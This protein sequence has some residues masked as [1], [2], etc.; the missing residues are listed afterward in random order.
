MRYLLVGKGDDSPSTRYRL[1]PLAAR[2]E[3]LGHSISF[4]SSD[5]S[6]HG[7]AGLLSAATRSDV[8][9]IQ[10]KLFGRGFL[11]ALRACCRNLIFD[12]DD[13]VF[14]QSDG[15]ESRTR[16]KRFAAVVGRS[17]M[18]W[19]GN[20]YLAAA[21]GALGAEAHVLPTAVRAE[22]YSLFERKHDVFTLVWIGSRST[23]R[24]LEACREELEAVGD[25]CDV[26]LKVIGDFDIGFDTIAVDVVPWSSATEAEELLRCHVGIAPMENNPWTRGKCVLKVLQY[27]ACGL[28]V[29]S[30]KTGANAEV[31]EHERTGLFAHT[32]EEWVAAVR[33][34]QAE[35]ETCR[36]FGE[37]GRR[38]VH[39]RYE[40]AHVVQEAVDH[41]DEAGLL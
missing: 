13:A 12:F 9:I 17:R 34:L 11:A 30:S 18:V 15:S 23:S 16:R 4:S 27:M 3:Q 14:V 22:Q 7:K 37:N 19:A 10:R 35:P 39:E 38:A 26:R 6:A 20:R 36:R 41:L 21:A 28:P 29:I 5:L 31:L 25:A 40:V 2:L 33:R 32:L 8:V 1:E 24:Y